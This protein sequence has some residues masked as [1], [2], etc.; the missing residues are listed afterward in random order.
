MK[1]DILKMIAR[2]GYAARG[3]VYFIVGGI[4]VAAA[5][6]PGGDAP[7][8]RG[9][10]LKLD[11]V[12]GG[13]VMLAMAAGLLC[14]ALWRLFQATLDADD[15]GTALKGAVIRIGLL[16]SA[17]TH[18]GLG[19]W[20]LLAVLGQAGGGD[21]GKQ[22]VVAW[23]MQQPYGPWFVASV[24]VCII[25]IGAAHLHKGATRGYEKWLKA[26]ERRMKLIRPVSS[27]GLIARG[28]VFFIAGGLFIYAGLTVDPEKAGGL[29][30]ALQW[31]RELPIGSIL[32]LVMAVGLVCFGAYSLIV[33]KYRR[34]RVAEPVETGAT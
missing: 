33:A 7:D 6:G 30:D 14:F 31:V 13:A 28:V 15:H 25:G 17:V 22:G 9:A 16:G 3:I 18:A 23:L 1:A 8:T 24:G 11:G 10:L 21:R 5:I 26:D 19:A 12:F 2:I 20:A 29:S 34:I 4:A 27:V 32:F